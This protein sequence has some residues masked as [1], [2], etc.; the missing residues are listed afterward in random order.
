MTTHNSTLEIA[1]SSVQIV[2]SDTQFGKVLEFVFDNEPRSTLALSE[3]LKLFALYNQDDKDESACKGEPDITTLTTS[4]YVTYRLMNNE[5][6]E[7]RFKLDD[8]GQRHSLRV[9]YKNA[10]C[11]VDQNLVVRYT[12]A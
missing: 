1:G 12:E 11:Y 4:Y 3:D 6:L 5:C 8:Q 9:L 2:R 10:R 7:L